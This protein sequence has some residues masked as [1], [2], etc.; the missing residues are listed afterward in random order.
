MW[1]RLS[2][3]DLCNRRREDSRL[4]SRSHDQKTPDLNHD[5][6]FSHYSNI[7]KTIPE[8]LRIRIP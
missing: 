8:L 7:L 6:I 1:E 2:S 3:R 5:R 4:E